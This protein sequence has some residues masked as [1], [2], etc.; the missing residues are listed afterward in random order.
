MSE[1]ILLN[2]P[3]PPFA[4]EVSTPLNEGE[5]F[6]P[7]SRKEYLDIAKPWELA[8]TCKVLGRSFSHDYLK[9][10]LGKVWN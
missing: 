1:S 7:I 10:E 3:E 4:V 5:V 8:I 2:L 6:I 9:V